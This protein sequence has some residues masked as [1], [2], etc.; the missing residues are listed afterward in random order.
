MIWQ[1]AVELKEV[2]ALGR[3]FAWP[4]PGRCLRCGSL[5]VWGHG[6]VGRYFDGFAQRLLLRCYRCAGCG[7]VMTP[8]PA[9]YVARVRARV[10]WIREELAHRVETGRWR[11]A[12]AARM[13]HWLGNLRRQALARLGWTPE[14]ALVAAF[15]RLLAAG[16]VAVSRAMGSDNRRGP[17]PPQ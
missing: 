14:H 2:A 7:C 5:R 1:V 10:A 17:L 6:L 13:R 4:R 9:G 15:D 3:A 12:P 8:R 11:S 16:V